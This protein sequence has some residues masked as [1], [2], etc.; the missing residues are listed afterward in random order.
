MPCDP[1]VKVKPWT[2]KLKTF[3]RKEAGDTPSLGEPLG[4]C[5]ED[6]RPQLTQE[7]GLSPW[8]LHGSHPLSSHIGQSHRVLPLRTTDEDQ[9]EDPR[10]PAPRVCCPFKGMANTGWRVGAAGLGNQPEG[11]IWSKLLWDP[12]HGVFTGPTRLLRGSLADSP[13]KVRNTALCG[14]SPPTT[15]T[16]GLWLEGLVGY[17]KAGSFAQARP[18]DLGLERR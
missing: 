2:I 12:C 7:P 16:V 6:W 8:R 17:S 10:S 3:P 4:V 9:S 13:S 11:A 1:R 5:T 15:H 18:C 14:P